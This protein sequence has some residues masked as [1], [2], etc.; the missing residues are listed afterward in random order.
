MTAA[1][2]ST[3]FLEANS[4]PKVTSTPN[5]EPA[6]RSALFQDVED[7][8]LHDDSM[9]EAEEATKK[10]LEEDQDSAIESEKTPVENN[11]TVSSE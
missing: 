5:I 1:S 10:S 4:P 7:E 2:N 8:F 11:R 9:A 6:S 3:K